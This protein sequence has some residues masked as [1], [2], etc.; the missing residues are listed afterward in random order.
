MLFNFLSYLKYLRLNSLPLPL[1]EKLVP[2][3]QR[4]NFHSVLLVTKNMF[5]APSLKRMMMVIELR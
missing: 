3:V 1:V 4:M 5:D 2:F